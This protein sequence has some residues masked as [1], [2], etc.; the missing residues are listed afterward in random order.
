MQVSITSS[1]FYVGTSRMRTRYSPGNSSYSTFWYFHL[2]SPQR[3]SWIRVSLEL[4]VGKIWRLKNIWKSLMNCYNVNSAL[5][6]QLFLTI[7][8]RFIFE[9]Y[10]FQLG[11][12]WVNCISHEQT[13]FKIRIRFDFKSSYNFSFGI[14][15]KDPAN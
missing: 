9:I 1:D 8:D 12:Y 15:F 6:M 3:R 13:N 2:T 7:D 4:L 14:T 11:K 10:M 5:E